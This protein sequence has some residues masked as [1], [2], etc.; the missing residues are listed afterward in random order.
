MRHVTVIGAGVVGACTALALRREGYAV[1]LIERGDPG[2]GT[3]YGNAG[4]LSVTSCVPLASP[5]ILWR[6]PHLLRDPLGPLAID[7]RYLP[8]LAPWLIRFVMASR[9]A[10][11]EHISRALMSLLVQIIP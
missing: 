6:V 2:M 1:T 7:W 11:V 4:M 10:R 5:G 9:P 8:K 3:S